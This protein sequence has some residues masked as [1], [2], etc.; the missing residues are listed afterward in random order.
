MAKITKL[1]QQW[2]ISHSGVIRT[3]A[4]AFHSRH[5]KQSSSEDDWWRKVALV[6]CPINASFSPDVTA[7]IGAR[8]SETSAMLVYRKNPVSI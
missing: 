8:N 2:Q 6:F 3:H 4:T 5:K 1:R 7:A